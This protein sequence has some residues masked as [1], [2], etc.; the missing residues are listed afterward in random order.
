MSRVTSTRYSYSIC[1]LACDNDQRGTSTRKLDRPQTTPLRCSHSG[2]SKWRWWLPRIGQLCWT[3]QKNAA[4][5]IASTPSLDSLP[6]ATSNTQRT[7]NM[8]HSLTSS[9]LLKAYM[10]FGKPLYFFSISFICVSLDG[11]RQVHGNHDDYCNHGD[12]ALD[13]SMLDHYV[14]RAQWVE[15]FTNLLQLNLVQFAST[16]CH[17]RRSKKT[18]IE[19]SHQNISN[20]LY[21]FTRKKLW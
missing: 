7:A 11:S 10:L 16:F 13:P 15:Q 17:Q 20:L 8:K 18:S 14:S 9:S 3:P 1:R 12:Q 6:H 4:L 21:Q 19:S 2:Y 5:H